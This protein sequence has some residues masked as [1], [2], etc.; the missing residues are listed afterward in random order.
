MLQK[1]KTVIAIEVKTEKKFCETSGLDLFVKKFNP[2]RVLLMGAQ[3]MALEKFLR[4]SI[5]DLF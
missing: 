4:S 5:L 2:S 1:G 3:G